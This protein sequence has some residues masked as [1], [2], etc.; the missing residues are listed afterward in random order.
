ME[1][2]VKRFLVLLL[3]VVFVASAPALAQRG[4]AQNQEK[5]KE[6]GPM[7]ASTFSGLK[8]RSIGPALTSG[9]VNMF[10]VDPNNRARYFAATA[11]GG[12]WK[13]TNGGATW[14]PVF[15][16]QG[17]YSIG[18]IAMDPKNPNVIW[19]GTGEYNS[20]RSVS[21]GDGVYKS[22]DGGRTW[23][24]M[25]LKKS[26]HIGRI[27]ID[28]NDSDTVYV[29]AQGPLWG[30]GGDRGLYKTTD[31]GK[32]WEK[33]LEISDDTG[34]NDVVMD[35]RDSNVLYASAW[36]RRRRVW[37][38]IN[39]GPESSLQKSTDGGK[40]WT[41]LTNGVP[42]GDVG[43]IGLAISPAN[44]D[45]VYAWIEAADGKGGIFRSTN[46]GASWERRNSFDSVSFYYGRV[47]A[48]PADVDR[49]YIMFT[50]IMV[51]DDGG[52]TI[53]RLGERF[54]HVDTHDLWID[55]NDTNYYLAGC[56][57]GIYESFDRGAN[58]AY[59]ANLP[60][61]QF[62]DI[63][64]DN[65]E[66]FYYVYGGTQDNNTLGGP[67]RTLESSGIHNSDWFVVTG[68]DGFKAQVDPEDPN[69]VYAE[70][71]YGGLVRHDRRT[72]VR[73][74]IKPQ[75]G[76]GE[77]PLRW[78]WDS[79]L[80]I[81]PHSN[82]RLYF[83]ANIVF[84]SDDRGDTWRAISPDLTRQLDRDTLKTMG[85][86]WG[87]EAVGRGQ[88]TSFYS[89][90]TV[91]AESPLQEGLLFVGTDD[92][93]LQITEDGGQNWTKSEKVGEAPAQIYLQRILPSQHDV[94][95]VYAVLDNHKNADFKPY[96]VK[97]TDRGRNWTSIASNLPENGPA[98]AI[99][100]DHVNPNLLFVGTEFGLFFTVDGGDKWI[101]LR[102]GLPT[103]AVRDVA[104]QKRENDLA[105]A[106]FGR[107]FYILDD[108]TPLRV[109]TKEML[110]KDGV[111]FP[112]KAA[113]MYIQTRRSGRNSQGAG[114][115]T[116]QNPSFGATFTYYIK[117]S[118][119][120]LK[121]KRLKAQKA[122]EKKGEDFP[123]P[124]NEEL[125][126]EAEEEKPAILLT[127][128]DAD[129]NVV[130]RLSGSG[131]KG[132]HRATWDLRYPPASLPRPGGGGGFGGRRRGA[133]GPFV[134]PGDY[135]VTLSRQAG[136]ETTVLAGPEKFSVYTLGSSPLQSQDRGAMLAFQ[137]K[138]GKLQ[139]AVN[140]AVQTASDV[141][142]RLGQ[143]V[144]ALRETPGDTDSLLQ[145]TLSIEKQLKD[146]QVA[147]SGDSV[148]R[149]QNKPTASSIS[150][151]INSVVFSMFSNTSQP[152][153]TMRES[154]R[155]AAE[156]FTGTLASLRTLVTVDLKNLEQQL[157]SIG[158]PW[159]P[160]RLPK[161]EGQ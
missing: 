91:I 53:R 139:G 43:R 160:G 100:E 7:S 76:K 113:P 138:V 114:F 10:A 72:G 17:T 107:S 35:P 132:I 8:L 124:S 62:Y 40:T 23:K 13:T 30:P 78:N 118:F 6:T 27:V 127:V 14:T 63:T 88:G 153:Q 142:R 33:I 45:V 18:A 79:P 21:Y 102:S 38:M 140:A 83:G 131:S 150:Q 41:K 93:L 68:G 57:G 24:N 89:N 156:E 130:R 110:D 121:Q 116:A 115:Y 15:D 49:I 64:V 19:V 143:I 4:R 46:R 11:S 144:R 25:G 123:F 109:V 117:E 92:G 135:N 75:E 2:I 28:P 158:A 108:Y 84:R 155:I 32:S 44:P 61:T 86:I 145:T 51:S 157:D 3:T 81:S 96:V 59:K 56:D 54:K 67:S 47:I 5:E 65:S 9:R 22:M 98:L 120:S 85:K 77:P 129:G 71:Q 136:G 128:N 95:T 149:Q 90:T 20:Q 42:K 52:K 58:W 34:V 104:I 152:T 74:P 31:G 161:W 16:K 111:L 97:S 148:L 159:T 60:L 105:L 151:R 82:T 103:I 39:G 69:I 29:A 101:R 134:V 133:S 146:V 106:T 122:A 99:A 112:V 48:D 147:L 137:R 50:F 37:T 36:Q 125:R 94:N 141:N 1:G 80:I 87:P 119:Q 73:S 154:Y 70:S 126:K 26:E 55:P 12:V 66:P